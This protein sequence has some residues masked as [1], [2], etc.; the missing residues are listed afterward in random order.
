MVVT[1]SPFASELLALVSAS[2][3]TCTMSPFSSLR[4]VLGW[5]A[6][7]LPFTTAAAKVCVVTL[8]TFVTVAPATRVL[9]GDDA[10]AMA[11]DEVALA[12]TE[13]SWRFELELAWCAAEALE[14]FWFAVLPDDAAGASVESVAS[15]PSVAEVKDAPCTPELAC[16]TGVKMP[17]S[18]ETRVHQHE[19]VRGLRAKGR[20]SLD[21]A[22]RLSSDT[23][24]SESHATFWH[25]APL[26]ERPALAAGAVQRA[27]LPLPLSYWRHSSPRV[28][29]S[30]E[31]GPQVGMS[32]RLCECSEVVVGGER[33]EGRQDE[34]RVKNE[35][36]ESG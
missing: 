33:G 2:L 22:S 31:R 20:T 13:E 18:G 8:R 7:A 17:A 26:D 27:L 14:L 5:T 1:T 25:S 36:T 34:E 3:V 24:S 4:L 30:A 32:P 19:Q 21:H 12:R 35:T 23:L 10:D 29:A 16:A 9:E 11:A 15:V 28:S 6:L